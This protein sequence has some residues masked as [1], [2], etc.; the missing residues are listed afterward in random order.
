MSPLAGV[1]CW[2]SQTVKVPF[3]ARRKV[4]RRVNPRRL[5]STRTSPETRCFR[6][7]ASP[8]STFGGESRSLFHSATR[9]ATEEIAPDAG[10]FSRNARAIVSE[11]LSH[12]EEEWIPV[13]ESTFVTITRGDV[14]CE[15]FAPIAP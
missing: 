12:L 4:A 1:R 7:R 5:A 13:P 10:H 15:P 11:P 6:S 14:T 9:D 3:V 8:A 2:R